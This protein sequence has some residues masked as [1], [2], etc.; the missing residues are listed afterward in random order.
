AVMIPLLAALTQWIGVKLAP[1]AQQNTAAQG[2]EENPMMSSMKMMNT[3]MPIMS[4][5]FCF[6]LPA[7]MGI[8]WIVGAVVR[9]I[10]QV[11]INKYIDK[12]DIDKVI[13]KNTA[14]YEEKLKKKGIIAQG[15]NNKAKSSTKYVNP[16]AR[17]KSDSSSNSAPKANTKA[18][19]KNDKISTSGGSIASKARMVKDFNEKNNK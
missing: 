7:G 2:Q 17:S 12:M 8:Y 14:K 3:F 13:E 6:S 15:I 16:Y 10:Q 18:N 9:C 11:A 1:N 19:A 5:V 4:A